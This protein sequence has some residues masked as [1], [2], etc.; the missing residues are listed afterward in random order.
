MPGA[1]R[2]Q[3]RAVPVGSVAAGLGGQAAGSESV[4][5]APVALGA[6]LLVL[7]AGATVAVG[8]RRRATGV[9]GQD[10]R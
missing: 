5:A 10:P 1:V 8:A 3:F 7:A 6:A 2:G 4:L 9:P